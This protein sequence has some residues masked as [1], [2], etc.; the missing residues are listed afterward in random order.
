MKRLL[1]PLLLLLI[2]V[3]HGAQAQQHVI[4]DRGFVINTGSNAKET[5]ACN[6]GTSPCTIGA[7]STTVLNA[8]SVRHECL[9]QNVG[10]TDFYCLKGTGTAS[11][12][13]MNF[14][15]KAASG[16]NKGDGGS[17]SC[18]TGPVVWTGIIACISSG[19]GGIL[20]A[21]AD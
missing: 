19:A 17:Y 9:L 6:A 15:L 21:S 12:A 18:N 2:L 10:T 20:N 1:L 11:T 13:N 5:I 3:P 14:V 8:N 7:S 16:A 4:V